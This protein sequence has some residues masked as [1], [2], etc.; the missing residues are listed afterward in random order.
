MAY[1]RQI[2]PEEATGEVKDFYEK[3]IERDGQVRGIFKLS[4]LRP[5]VMFG[6]S[7]LYGAVMFGD[8]DLSR[9]QRE[10]IA[11]VVSAVNGCVY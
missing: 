2:E 8:S 4:S 9:A 11:T 10:M 3:L 7:T 5:P 1:V 6:L